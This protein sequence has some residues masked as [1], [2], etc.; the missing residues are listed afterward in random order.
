MALAK[1]TAFA[2]AVAAL[3]EVAIASAEA[4]TTPT[5]VANSFCRNYDNPSKSC[6]SF[7]RLTHVLK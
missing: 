6:R 2:Q 4:K 5:E 7:I 1:T 3:A